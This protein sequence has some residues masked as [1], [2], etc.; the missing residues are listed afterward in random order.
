LERHIL[1]SLKTLAKFFTYVNECSFE[2]FSR[3]YLLSTNLMS[4][5]VE[6]KVDKSLFS[7]YKR[8]GM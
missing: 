1:I 5:R 7:L 4:F 2:V 8:E 6:I 3:R